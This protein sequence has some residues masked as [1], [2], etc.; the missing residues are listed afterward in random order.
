MLA[1]DS[2]LLYTTIESPLGELLLLGDGDALHGLY[3]QA[4]PKPV[5]I[6]PSWKRAPEA[7]AEPSEQ[8]DQY[9]AARRT[10]F[11]VPLVMNGTPFQQRVWAGLR[12]IGYGET[13]S[14]GELAR[15]IGHPSGARAVGLANGCN[16][17]SVIVPC[18]RVIGANGTLTGYGGGLER[19]RLLLDLEARASAPQLDYACSDPV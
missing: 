6:A 11:E 5:A 16:P 12:E 3:M 19:K 4:A 7:F 9:F 10:S 14:Y 15:R 17:I 13:L 8:L 2:T 18:H 1:T